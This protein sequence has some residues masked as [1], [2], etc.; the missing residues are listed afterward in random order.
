MKIAVS[1]SH[2]MVFCL[3]FDEKQLHNRP[4]MER[5]TNLKGL[6][7]GWYLDRTW[8]IETSESCKEN[9]SEELLIPIWRNTCV[10]KMWNTYKNIY[11]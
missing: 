2:M 9:A 4:L 11:T 3:T 1:T 10:G 6:G 7:W 8:V 5:M